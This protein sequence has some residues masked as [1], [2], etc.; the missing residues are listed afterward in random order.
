MRLLFTN[1][2]L[3]VTLAIIGA[4]T[5]LGQQRA[6]DVYLDKIKANGVLRVGI[7]P[8]YPPFDSISNGKIEGYD[9]G[10]ARAIA[11]DLNVQVEFVP[12]ALD[13]LYDALAAG[14]VDV[15][16]SAL[17]FI[18]E[19]Q[20]DVRY[21]QSYYQAGQVIVVKAGNTGITTAKDLQGKQVG[22]E[23]GSSADTEARRLART[24]VTGMKLRSIYQ[25]SG[26]ALDAVTRGELDA[27]ITDNTSA[28]AYRRE[29]LSNVTQLAPPLTDEPFVIALPAR[30]NGLGARIDSEI[31]RLAQSGE[32]ARMMGL[33]TP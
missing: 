30:A 12:L 17:P 26:E 21:S 18:Y 23:L 7:D 3:V 8:T 10:L 32:L 11:S 15:L 19:R 6:P 5:W 29:H 33:A 25:S 20:G 27:V 1:I 4:L 28:Q 22:T 2:L 16:I 13:S 9:A 14:K 31:A 24:T